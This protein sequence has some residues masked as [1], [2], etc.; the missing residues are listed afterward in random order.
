VATATTR[1]LTLLELLQA[2]GR[3]TGAE[4][5]ERLEVD[6]RSVRRYVTMLQDLGIPISGERG[7][8]GGY[9]LR[10]GFKLPPLMFTEEEA[11]ALTLGLLSARRTGLAAAA[12]AVEGALA[13]VDRVL[14]EAVRDQVRAV[15]ETLHLDL[16][17]PP[18][19]P[20]AGPATVLA[21]GAAA[22][23]RR[24]LR[25]RY[26]SPER[27]TER[28]FDTYGVVF[29]TGRWYAVGWCH[30]AGEVRT[31]RLDRVL[32][33][34]ATSAGFVPPAGFDA[35]AHLVRSLARRYEPWTVEVLMDTTLEEASR[36]ILPIVGSLTPTPGGVLLTLRA[37]S[38]EWV[39]HFL[40]R[41]P[42]PMEV[43]GPPELAAALHA[44]A[45]RLSGAAA[46]LRP[47]P[48]SRP[49]AGAGR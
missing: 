1:L 7:R 14:P 41:I 37:N 32:E 35:H 16:G 38:L 19:I 21:F 47:L 15:Q 30:L 4:L 29:R 48:D 27:I 17:P 39:A 6:Q 12:P 5:A 9:R 34:E 45:E 13:K 42:W 22:R 3:L 49:A 24:R 43:A 33:V 10:R 11:L 23:E 26:Q 20:P 40:S 18:T 46:T 25:L 2:R 44:L 36:W 31:F 28:E 8:H